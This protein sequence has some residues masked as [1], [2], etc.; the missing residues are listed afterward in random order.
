MPT[1]SWDIILGVVLIFLG[2]SFACKLYL[3]GAEGRISYWSGFVPFSIISPFLLHLPAGKHSPVRQVHALW[4]YF[5]MAPIFLICSALCLAAGAEYFGLPGV[6][7]LNWIIKCGKDTPPVAITFDKKSG[8]RFPLIPR[9]GT[10]FGDK[11]NKA[12]IP[13]AE[14]RQANKIITLLSTI[15]HCH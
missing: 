4:V 15:S 8:Y 3:A 7:T 5:I 13:L 14:K 10:T 11:I 2:C 9:V 1:G 6:S 12:Q